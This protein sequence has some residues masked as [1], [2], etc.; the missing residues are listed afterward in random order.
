MIRIK[1]KPYQLDAVNFITKY[2]NVIIADD[3]GIGKSIESLI[4]VDNLSAY[5]LI[6]VCPA[7]AKHK[8]K[9]EV[10]KALYTMCCVVNARTI[11]KINTK[12]IVIIN[13]DQVEKYLPQLLQ[14]NAKSVIID[15]S[16]LVKNPN[17]KRSQIIRLLIN[18]IPT[19][20]LLT[21]T[22]IIIRADDLINQLVLINRLDEIGGEKWFKH[23]ISNINPKEVL[24]VLGNKL[25]TIMLRRTKE[26]VLKL[27]DKRIWVVNIDIKEDT[28]KKIDTYCNLVDNYL[29]KVIAM[30]QY[31]GV[32]KVYWLYKNLQSIKGNKKVVI[33]TKFRYTQRLL[34]ILYPHCLILNGDMGEE[35]K[36]EVIRQFKENDEIKI[37]V[38]TIQC[39]GVAVEFTSASKVIFLDID[40]SPS[41]H[42]QAMDRVHRLGQEDE[43]D[44]YYILANNTIDNCL[45][46]NIIYKQQEI[47]E[48]LV[49]KYLKGCNKNG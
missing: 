5:P 36:D 1:L 28:H 20:I 11:T 14:Y 38:C 49:N 6:I 31:I 23:N 35:R 10:N 33:F 32:D 43:V 42:K 13:Y 27:L 21:G 30:Q 39:A 15:E 7:I 2:R 37:L 26:E 46:N 22:P 45:Y 29:T 12:Q 41:V 17:T 47:N 8:W 34:R 24:H 18:D 25:K 16:H 9:E 44:V 19:R 4:G 40:F 48:V 3:M